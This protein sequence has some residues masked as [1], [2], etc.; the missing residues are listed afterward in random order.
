MFDN[1][2]SR[3]AAVVYLSQIKAVQG[4]S[5]RDRLC[6][7]QPDLEE[8]H[9]VHY[10]RHIRLSAEVRISLPTR[11]R[12]SLP[13]PAALENHFVSWVSSRAMSPSVH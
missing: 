8:S 9:L 4:I 13:A 2:G 6:R 12:A 1:E 5:T 3:I 11:G 10:E 7:S